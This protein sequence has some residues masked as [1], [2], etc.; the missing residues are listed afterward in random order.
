VDCF[1]RG[2]KKKS[3]FSFVC[4][5]G[6]SIKKHLRESHG[7]VVRRAGPTVLQILI[8]QGPGVAPC[9]RGEDSLRN[10]AITRFMGADLTNPNDQFL[11][12]KLR[13]HFSLKGLRMLLLDWITYHNLPFQT[14]HSERFQRILLYGNP[15][16][17]RSHLPSAKTLLRMLESEYR[18]AIGPVTEVLRSARS[19]IHFSFDGW[20]V[21]TV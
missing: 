20:D 16:L 10:Q 21:E 3:A 14:V 6:I 4:S 13:A 15:L 18:G 5:T 19:Q 17:E 7:I 2:F 1:A 11:L 12:G 8:V 9:R